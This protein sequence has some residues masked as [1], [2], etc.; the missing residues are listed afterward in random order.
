M[1]DRPSVFVVV[2]QKYVRLN[3]IVLDHAVKLVEELPIR[4][5]LRALYV[6]LAQRIVSFL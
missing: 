6:G 3:R 1:R 5:H 4:F 2:A